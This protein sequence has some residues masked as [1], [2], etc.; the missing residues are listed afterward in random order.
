[1]GSK[2]KVTALL[3]ALAA[4][5]IAVFA[6]G[7]G[8]SNS[9]S[10]SGSSGAKPLTVGSD[11]PYPPFEEFGKSKTEFKG[12]DVE[13]MEAV[14]E[15]IGREAQFQDT[16]FATIFRDL[17][18]GKFE[19]VASATTITPER[20]KTVDF[21]DPYYLSEQAILVKEGSEINSVAKLNGATVAVQQGTT[22]QEFVEKETEAGEVRP[23]PEGPDAVQAV[24]SGTSDAAVIDYPVAQDAVEKSSGIEISTA[25]PTE[26]EYGFVVAQG[27]EELLN[28]LN[29]GLMEVKEDGTYTKIYKKWFHREPPKAIL[30]ATHKAS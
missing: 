21:T 26:E 27:N 2:M 15:R 3:L 19:A 9:G 16:S 1:M 20:E 24:Q 7:C 28:E 5:A 29:K 25:I 30:T 14:A 22:G 23:F 10:T 12:F 18:Q 13:L 6:A 11:V 4:C 8:S 17:G